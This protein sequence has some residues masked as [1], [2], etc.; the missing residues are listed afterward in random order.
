MVPGGTEREN[1]AFELPRRGVGAG[2]GIVPGDVVLEDGGD[3]RI[4]S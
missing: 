1:A 3:T 2:E 4:Q